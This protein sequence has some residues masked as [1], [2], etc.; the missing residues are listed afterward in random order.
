MQFEHLKGE[1]AS[2]SVLDKFI[3]SVSLTI[4]VWSKRGCQVLDLMH[5]VSDVMYPLMTSPRCA[6]CTRLVEL[7]LLL[8]FEEIGERSS[9]GYSVCHCYD[10]CFGFCR[11]L[12]ANDAGDLS[13]HGGCAGISVALCS[14]PSYWT[15]CFQW[16]APCFNPRI[17][18][19][20]SYP[21]QILWGMFEYSASFNFSECIIWTSSLCNKARS[22]TL[23]SGVWL[24]T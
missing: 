6:V 24:Y 17:L 16:R 20:Q 18:Q 8:Y 1:M 13:N 11:L 23:K 15:G 4:L 21:S 5:Q 22:C 14:S 7:A 9:L 10:C 2:L 12:H 19:W 3:S